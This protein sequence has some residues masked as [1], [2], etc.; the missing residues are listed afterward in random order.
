MKRALKPLTTD[1][2]ILKTTLGEDGGSIGA[3]GLV[4]QVIALSGVS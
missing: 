3:A 4:F 2:E 1:V